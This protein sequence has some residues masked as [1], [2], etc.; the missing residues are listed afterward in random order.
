MT[1]DTASAAAPIAGGPEIKTNTRR[2]WVYGMGQ[3]LL[4]LI[5]I[6]L[7]DLKTEGVK[8]I[9]KHGGV[10]IVS[11][12]QSYLDPG[13]LG[14]KVK[15]PMS[16]MAKSELF[17]NKFFAGM[18]TAVNAYPVR[19]GDGDV[20]AVRETINRL[21]EGHVLV[22]FPEGGRTENGEIEKMEGGMGLIV[23]RAGPAVKV[24]PAAI[25]GAYQA[26]PR[27]SLLPHPSPIRV[28]YGPA[29][30]LSDKRASEIVKILEG[31]IHRL[32]EE[33]KAQAKRPAHE[34]D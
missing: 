28:K 24:V 9:P 26:W 3:G 4:K 29:L 8:N 30:D 11:N 15:R 33:L 18:I 16:F 10:L 25:Y 2:T 20:G 22:M 32:F 7:F 17:V 34:R 1:T 27:Q 13:V 14:V 31:E 21:Q 6:T 12:H 23:R 5:G 19:Q